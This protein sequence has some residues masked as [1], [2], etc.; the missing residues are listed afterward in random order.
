[1]KLGSMAKIPMGADLAADR[2]RT[3]NARTFGAGVS[4][5]HAVVEFVTVPGSF[6]LAAIT[7]A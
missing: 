5:F 7:G 2:N 6:A 4:N 1:M 3:L